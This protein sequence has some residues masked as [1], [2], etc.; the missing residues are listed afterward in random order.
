LKE[1]LKCLKIPDKKDL[2]RRLTKCQPADDLRARTVFFC[3]I[4]PNG[5]LMPQ[6]ERGTGCLHT[7]AFCGLARD[8]YWKLL[9][10]TRWPHACAVAPPKS[11]IARSM[12]MYNLLRRLIKL[13]F[14]FCAELPFCLSCCAYSG[15][16]SRALSSPL[17]DYLNT[18]VFPGPS[19]AQVAFSNDLR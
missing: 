13:R 8:K 12:D 11:I 16:P 2:S 4:S 1:Q 15:L 19:L 5:Y 6:C 7:C 10:V 14:P 3:K 9:V 18:L 17:R